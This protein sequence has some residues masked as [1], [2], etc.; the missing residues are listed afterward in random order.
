MPRITVSRLVEAPQHEVWTLIS[1]IANAGRWNRSWTKIEFTSQQSHGPGARFRAHTEPGDAFEFEISEWSAPDRIAFRPIRNPSEPA[2]SMT[3]DA[4]V[5]DLRP[6]GG[7]GQTL[8]EITA[9]AT[10]RGFRGRV[11]AMFFW[12]GHQREGLSAALD[13]IA[14]VFEP[15]Q[16][17]P[18]LDDAPEALSE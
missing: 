8:V 17:G 11:I 2:Y 13:A 18:E 14:A 16:D 4:H 7:E 15:E 1:D 5:F 6:A 9:H 3:L 12:A 10:A